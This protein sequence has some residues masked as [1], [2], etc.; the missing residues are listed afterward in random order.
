[1]PI[2]ELSA[3]QRAAIKAQIATLNQQALAA[4]TN[5]RSALANRNSQAAEQFRLQ[6]DTYNAEA[7]RLTELLNTGGTSV[8][9]P[10][11]PL[12]DNFIKSLGDTF[13]KNGNQDEIHDALLLKLLFGT[14][15]ASKIATTDPKAK[16]Y[17]ALRGSTN[18]DRS[19]LGM[20][21]YWLRND[22]QA[23]AMSTNLRTA[24]AVEKTMYPNLCITDKKVGENFFI[25]DFM[26]VY[27]RGDMSVN[28]LVITDDTVFSAFAREFDRWIEAINRYLHSKNS[29]RTVFKFENL[30]HRDAIQLI[31]DRTPEGINHF[32]GA[33]M[34]N[35]RL[36]GNVIQSTVALQGIFAMD[37]AFKYLYI[38][39]NH[40][41]IGGEHTI[42]IGGM[43]SGGIV[44][45]TDLNGNPL[46]ASKI[47]LYPL[48]L[49]GGA[50]IYVVG[51]HNKPNLASN[52]PY[53]YA[54]EPIEGVK[55]ESDL[56][57]FVSPAIR[58]AGAQFYTAVDM[59]ELHA[60]LKQ[61]LQA[62]VTTLTT[63]QWQTTM[64]QLVQKGFAQVVT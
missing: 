25:R 3:A 36:L 4:D 60:I 54:Y 28:N 1:M 31:P 43:L 20:P 63:A 53:Y 45:N 8:T 39:D 6:R 23:Q 27:T 56:R 32:G 15:D 12:D 30:A 37:G 14:F 34:Q 64:A 19:K 61:Y 42:T 24:G 10:L 62:G 57:H 41:E 5:M 44:G 58:K 55:P 21:L 35:M 59:Q 33:I 49:G 22:Q 11:P 29:I 2:P 48:R 9:N 13:L 40:L 51:F 50:N 7:K 38:L 52:S 18:T 17:A 46:P 47:K 16:A 26:Q